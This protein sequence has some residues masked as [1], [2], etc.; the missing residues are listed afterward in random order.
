[1]IEPLL[2]FYDR[3]L[4]FFREMSVEFARRYPKIAARLS[5]D[6]S[7]SQDPHVER[8]I[9]AFALMN[10]RI[11]HKLDDDFPELAEAM[12]N[13]LYPHY[14]APNPSMAIVQFVHDRKQGDLTTGSLVPSGTVLESDMTDGERCTYRTAYPVTLWPI[15]VQS[16]VF[17]PCPFAAPKTLQGGLAQAVV[18]IQLKTLSAATTFQALKPSTLRFHIALPQFRQATTLYELL[19]TGL[20]DIV[21]ASSPDDP[22]PVSLGNRALKPVGF[23]REQGLLPFGP[24]SFRGY[25][26]LT[27]YF[28]FPQKFLFFDLIGLTPAHWQ[29]FAD[30][31][32]IYLY[33]KTENEELA[34]FVS[35][36]TLRLGCTPIVNLFSQPADPL[37]LSH[38]QTEYRVVPDA[39]RESALEI[40]SV[41]RVVASSPRGEEMEYAPF[42]S[43]RH[44]GS[45]SQRTFWH[46]VRRART[47][48]QGGSEIEGT[49]VHLTLVDLDFVPTALA[50][51]TLHLETTCLNRGRRRVWRRARDESAFAFRTERDRYPT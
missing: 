40:Y 16:A 8:M 27:E 32:G 6:S 36:D 21:L 41:D 51:L 34:R 5:L 38:R 37:H 24:R 43:F 42:Y 30:R 33:L 35:A 2:S 12:L 19:C 3:E 39:R 28:V 20:V 23:E 48:E 9:Q 13:V 15:D 18:A 44:G 29:K 14:I 1:M 10:A 47:S 22:Y 50:D 4:E 49:E 26:L 11:R 25:R 31:V 7:G 45:G 46:S 17:A